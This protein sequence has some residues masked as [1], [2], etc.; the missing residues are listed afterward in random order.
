M[1]MK[2]TDNKVRF[3][4][5][6]LAKSKYQRQSFEKCTFDICGALKDMTRSLIY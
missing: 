5:P 2:H 4:V 6:V 1:I 3:A